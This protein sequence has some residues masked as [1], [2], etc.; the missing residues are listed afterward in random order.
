MFRKLQLMSLWLGLK[1]TSK[2]TIKDWFGDDK[3]LPNYIE[4]NLNDCSKEQLIFLIDKYWNSMC[5]I[6]EVC[7]DESKI[8]ISSEK[9]V[10]E[11]R[12]ELRSLD[13]PFACNS[14]ILLAFID[15]KMGKNN[16][17][18]YRKRLRLED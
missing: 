11:I 15:Y 17:S 13:F 14:E 16:M 1:T 2:N 9:A 6:S 4:E 5:I 12:E 8:N 3:M 10:N 18:E 7:V